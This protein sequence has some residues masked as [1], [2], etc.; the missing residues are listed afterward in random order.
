MH[1]IHF[2]GIGGIGLSA[3]ARYLHKNGFK[4]SGSDIAN[5]TLTKALEK[6]GIKVFVPQVAEN[7]KDYD[8][9]VYTAVVKNDNPE[10]IEAKKK[11]HKNVF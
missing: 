1:K 3:I 6:E 9:V 11:G 10:L 2:I 4:V 5:T 8:V 7:I